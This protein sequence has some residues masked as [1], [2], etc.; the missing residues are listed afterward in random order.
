M[1]T[2]GGAVSIT[3]VAVGPGDAG[4]LTLRGK[5]ALREADLVAGFT[6]VLDVVRPWLDHAEVCPM[7]YQDQE[8][9][10]EYAAG[11]AR[12]GRRC[13]VCCWGDLNVSARELLERVRARVDSMEL[14]PG[15]SSVQVACA[16]SG[17]SL[18][19]ALFIT[20][21]KRGDTGGDLDEL[22][23]YLREGRRHVILIPRPWDLMPA[24]I[25]QQLLK[26]GIPG[27]RSLT[28]YQRLTLDGEQGWNGTLAECAVLA[29]EFSDLTIMVF[30]RPSIEPG[31]G[32]GDGP[33]GA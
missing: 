27:Q 18:E 3:V 25:S 16:R 11:Q 10:L 9:V 21:H 33:R 2:G 29:E 23:H 26:S 19:D 20:L 6:T 32:A 4:F 28:I 31:N 22:E 13:V 7:S 1:T 14:V 15:I 17:T 5:E 12:K 24:T 8:D 30:S